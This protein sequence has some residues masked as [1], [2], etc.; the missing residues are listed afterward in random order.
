ML[1]P[2]VNKNSRETQTSGEET[3]TNTKITHV[4]GGQ[5]LSGT[6]EFLSVLVLRLGR[7]FL[8]PVGRSFNFQ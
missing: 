7:V 5:Y 8:L 6:D 2:A 4:A 3:L 1:H